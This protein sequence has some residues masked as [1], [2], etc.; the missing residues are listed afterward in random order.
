LP[1]LPANHRYRCV[2]AANLTRNDG[3]GWIPLN[4]TLI[5]DGSPFTYLPVDPINTPASFYSYT[6]FPGGRA[7][8][9]ARIE[10]IRQRT[11]HPP[12]ADGISVF[13]THFTAA[14]DRTP[15][16]I[17]QVAVPLGSAA[18]PSY[19]FV[20]DL[21]TGIFSPL[22]DNIGFSTTGAER[23]RIDDI[24]RVGIG[25]STLGERLTVAGIIH[26]TIGGIRF[27][28]GT[29]QATAG[30]ATGPGG[31]LPA[32]T[33][34]QTLRH[35][36]TAWVADSNLFNDGTNMGI[37][38]TAPRDRVD[39][40]GRLVAGGLIEVQGLNDFAQGASIT[41]TAGA[42]NNG[43]PTARNAHA[44]WQTTTFPSS[45][46]LDFNATIHTIQAISFA[47]FWGQDGRFIPRDYMILHSLD[48]ATWT[49]AVNVTGNTRTDVYHAVG[50]TARCIRL[51][52]N[53]PQP[54]QT[55]A[56]VSALQVLS[57]NPSFVGKGPF[58]PTWG[59][60]AVFLGGNVGIG[61]NAPLSRVQIQGH[62][63]TT[64]GTLNVTDSAGTS[65]FFVRD[66]GNVG[67]GTTSPG[68]RLDV[69][70]PDNSGGIRHTAV[71][72]V[73]LGTWADSTRGGLIGTFS[74]HRF[75]IF[76][77]SGAE[78]MTVDTAGNVGIGTAAPTQRLQVQGGNIYLAPE[79]AT[80]GWD[81]PAGMDSYRIIG[82][83]EA[84][85]RTMRIG[86]RM[87]GANLRFQTFDSHFA[88][89]SGDPEVTRMIIQSGGNVGI[90]TTGPTQRLDVASGNIA[91]GHNLAATN[92][93]IKTF[94]TG[95]AAGNV[96]SQLD[97][98]IQD[99]APAGI[100]IRNVRDG[101]FNSQ[102]I[103]FLT[104]HGGVSAGTRMVIDRAGN[105]GIGTS[106]PAARLQNVGD[107]YI[108]SSINRGQVVSDTVF[109][110]LKIG[111]NLNGSFGAGIRGV[112]MAGLWSDNVRLDLTT[113]TT[114]NDLTQTP[115]L[116][117]MPIS[118]NVGI[119]TTAPGARLEV[120]G[121][122][123]AAAPTAT[124]HVT[125]MGWVNERI[126]AGQADH[127]TTNRCWSI[128]S[129]TCGVNFPDAPCPVGWTGVDT[130]TYGF[131]TGHMTGG[132]V[133]IVCC[134]ERLCRR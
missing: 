13:A 15:L 79:G 87:S 11:I 59:G 2:T 19:T 90:G 113:T 49:T 45:I 122:I 98:I 77:N 100:S 34:G 102:S 70:S 121:N 4:F 28:D 51:T 60:N 123:I 114:W 104:H 30:G 1:I 85:G 125:T 103:E 124:N 64:A 25:T 68:V 93:V 99:G 108:T 95:H 58:T 52:I 132:G 118:G 55:F 29:L 134:R 43:G 48:C 47:S 72:G 26:S 6:P 96:P 74:N 56:N 127:I 44:H 88:F 71:G 105:V 50:F 16:G 119:G 120:A 82:G 12:G 46:T 41:V 112:Q 14:V 18:A 109:G 67:I 10:S 65:R 33:A 63:T 66:D 57:I 32:G 61:M 130:W 5:H 131:I 106:A 84:G 73:I 107:L 21:N 54:G 40:I 115:R 36:G 35:S 27:P 42:L 91:L 83:T 20:G 53:A 37:G 128:G 39:V 126:A 94:A 7:T 110:T 17:G 8:F 3:G 116:S 117:V 129:H 89:N 62:G 38:T 22:A 24:G 92:Q 133:I 75:G 23:M 76:T 9:A 111:A 80:I 81:G 86:S 78:R 31:A 69:A 101:T 97:F